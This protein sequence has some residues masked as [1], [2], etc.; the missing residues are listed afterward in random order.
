MT[1][2]LSVLALI[3]AFTGSLK[4]QSAPS[5]RANPRFSIT[6]SVQPTSL[7]V[8]SPLTCY[9]TLT[10]TSNEMVYLFAS[11]QWMGEL[12]F[13]IDVRDEQ[14]KRAPLT[15]Y[16][17]QVKGESPIPIVQNA[18]ADVILHPGESFKR[19]IDLS[20]V[21]NLAQPGKYNIQT[22][23]GDEGAVAKSNIVTVTVAPKVMI[24][25]PNTWGVGVTGASLL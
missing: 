1:R 22:E 6:I 20:K 13:K 23:R 18:T 9:A 11:V 4:A 25:P 17:R 15:E 2:R 10:N 7:K 3:L 24:T 8:G 21:Y 12:D 5:K 19:E 16:G 14:G